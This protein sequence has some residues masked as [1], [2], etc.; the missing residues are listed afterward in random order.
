M[1]SLNQPFGEIKLFN[2]FL[3][4]ILGLGLLFINLVVLGASLINLK[5]SWRIGILENQK[6]KLVTR[7]IYQFTRNPYFVS[8]F[9]MFASYTILLQNLLL[10]GLSILGF[11]FV[12]RMIIKEEKYLYSVHGDAYVKYRTKVPR[13]III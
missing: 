2:D 12:H 3:C 5:D 8:Y 6:T 9:L 11:L 10:F 7:G 1:S 4:S 13:Y